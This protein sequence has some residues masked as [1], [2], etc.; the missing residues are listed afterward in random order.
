M[1]RI[2]MG[3]LVLGALTIVSCSD[4]TPKSGNK[5]SAIADG[6]AVVDSSASDGSAAAD[7]AMN[8]GA[9]NDGAMNDS[10]A[11]DGATADAGPAC[12]G[13]TQPSGFC[14][15]PQPSC[16]VNGLTCDCTGVCSGVQ[17]QPG[18]EYSW[19]CRV[20]I[21]ARCPVNPPANGASC[22]GLIGQDCYW[23][24]RCSGTEATC[25]SSGKWKVTVHSPPP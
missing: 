4:S 24:G 3:A 5:D 20:K 22:T 14:A 19:W 6:T 2:G 16:F 1:K 25:E 10:G 15:P 8:D 17:P 11:T 13:T 9:M 21:S 7:G 18:E 23:G 12:S